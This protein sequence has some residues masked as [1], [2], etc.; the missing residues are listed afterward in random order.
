M[1]T[2][3][4][5]PMQ[6]PVYGC[7]VLILL[8]AIIACPA[9]AFTAKTLDI[10]IQ[11]SS[12]AVI[13]FSYELSWLEQAAVFS[14]IADP[15]NE[16]ARALRTQFNRDVDVISVTGNSAQFRVKD[17]ATRKENAGTVTLIAPSLSFKNA[18]KALQRYWFARL[19]NP[20][21]SPDVTRVS[22]PD[23]YNEEFYNLETIP[24]VRHTI[25]T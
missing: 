6:Y 15:A 2:S 14:K 19:I 9:Q 25:N 21:F 20:D 17:F 22:F 7:A 10:T 11:D 12:D 24:S 3:E 23:G 16:L 13:T 18:E 4:E 1:Y 5:Y 8:A